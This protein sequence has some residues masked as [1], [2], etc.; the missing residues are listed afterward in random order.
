MKENDAAARFSCILFNWRMRAREVA[1]TLAVAMAINRR[2]RCD[3]FSFLFAPFSRAVSSFSAA[4]IMTANEPVD[5]TAAP[6]CVCDA[7]GKRES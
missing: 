6:V 3:I 4:N 1:M 5:T 2:A 7:V